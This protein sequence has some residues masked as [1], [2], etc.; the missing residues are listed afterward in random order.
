LLAGIGPGAAAAFAE[1]HF[2]RAQSEIRI[3]SAYFSLKGY[4]LGWKFIPA[5]V[6]L[7]ILVG[8]GER[9]R[10][11]VK[12]A[13][14]AELRRELR[15]CAG[16][17]D[18][19]FMAVSAV[20]R[21]IHNGQ[22]VIR[23]ARSTE[24]PFHCKFYICDAA[25]LW[26]GSANYS[27]N[28]LTGQSEQVEASYHEQQIRQWTHWFDSVEQEAY[29]LLA[30]V[31]AAL[32]DWLNMAKPFDAYL[33]GLSLLLNLVEHAAITGANH[34]VYYQQAI[35]ATATD[36]IRRYGGA[37]LVV[38]TGLGK[39]IIGAEI[40]AR[41]LA[42]QMIKQ[43]LLFAPNGVHAHW[44]SELTPRR[45]PVERYANE[46]LFNAPV[47]EPH[48]QISV[49]DEW[50]RGAG[51][52]SLIVIDEAHSYG[53][54]LHAPKLRG[55]AS[56]VFERLEPA[57][58]RGA[59]ILLLTAS[60][61]RTNLDNFNSLL[62]L[63]PAPDSHP[64]WGRVAWRAESLEAFLTLAPVTVF[65]MR[66]LLRLARARGDE[67]A[68]KRPFVVFNGEQRYLP[69]KLCFDRVEFDLPHQADVQA[70][71][72]S[73]CFNQIRPAPQ[74]YLDSEGTEHESVSERIY[75]H[76]MDA[77]LSSPAAFCECLTKNLKT[78]GGSGHPELPFIDEAEP[79]PPIAAVE[80]LSLLADAVPEVVRTT[81]ASRRKT[82]GADHFHAHMR[83]PVTE[84][85]A[86]LNPLNAALASSGADPNDDDKFRR[87]AQVLRERCVTHSDKVVVFVHRHATAVYLKRRLTKVFGDKVRVLSTVSS[88]RKGPRLLSARLR[89][90]MLKK[91]SPVSHGGKPGERWDVLI[92]TNADGV[93]VNLQDA[94]T[95]VHYDLPQSAD[96]LMQR[97]GRVLRLTPDPERIIYVYTFEPALAH[98]KTQHSKAQQYV[99]SRVAR[100]RARD[101][102][103]SRIFGSA[104]MGG[105][106]QLDVPLEGDIDVE[107]WLGRID[108]LDA[109]EATLMS[110]LAVLEAHRPR[111]DE[112]ATRNTVH[113]ARHVPGGVPQI[114]VIFAYQDRHRAVAFDL[115][116][117]TILSEDPLVVLGFLRCD[118]REPLAEVPVKVVVEAADAAVTTWCKAHNVLPSTIERI[119]AVYLQP[120]HLSGGID[121]LLAAT[122]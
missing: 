75:N 93:G 56:V 82:V 10:R 113:S 84:R 70:A 11:S 31:L 101:Q 26:H 8:K 111:A 23:A 53:N 77:W 80:Q 103:A 96:P 89:G 20:V 50:L 114:V 88:T 85:A 33:L 47:S 65:G 38:A 87:L 18:E 62:N 79:A 100:I 57:V 2:P 30:D 83:L 17:A 25:S 46:I 115:A 15:E 52:D 28:G 9:D 98:V 72:D 14:I 24:A 44:S 3:A 32:E 119:A 81:S 61:Y 41:M 64:L 95:I 68:N 116:H 117:G 99:A 7:H 66:H 106:A 97:M 4:S 108:T 49:V 102:R 118:E 76:S 74:A 27:A 34:P 122:L 48:Y 51:S 16:D 22:F 29:D 92:C 1:E 54:E 19:M 21:R 67:D 94:N 109:T 12:E 55:K 58:A 105:K 37:L 107:D 90:A 73:G 35:I 43:V 45:V 5:G 59:K 42:D 13:V 104:T 110:H 112:L 121:Q 120:T 40:A 78:N 69:R 39:T 91:F 86:I 63:L 36:H 71:F 60:P 6:P